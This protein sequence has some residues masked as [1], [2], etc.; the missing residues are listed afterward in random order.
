MILALR[1]KNLDFDYKSIDLTNREQEKPDFQVI[2][3]ESQVPV[4]LVNK[5][6]LTQSLAIITYIDTL[7]ATNVH[8][9]FPE[10]K[11]AH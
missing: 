9:L 5:R 2:S 7:S 11:D 6:P 10:I 1:Y 8:P 4:L 3:S